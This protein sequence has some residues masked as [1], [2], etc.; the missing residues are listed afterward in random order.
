MSRSQ[1]VWL[2]TAVPGQMATGDDIAQV[3]A[4]LRAARE[5]LR[6][7]HESTRTRQRMVDEIGRLVREAD[8]GNPRRP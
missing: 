6:E 1:H 8:G 5:E 7:L 2:S 3:R 4:E